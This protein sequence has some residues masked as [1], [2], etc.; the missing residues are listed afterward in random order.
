MGIVEVLGLA[1][2][3]TAGI[4]SGLG[5]SLPTG[6]G[7]VVDEVIQTDAALNPGNSGGPLLD[8]DGRVVGMVT[9]IATETG[10]NEGIGFAVPSA[11]VERTAERII[12][13][14]RADL[15]Y[16]G[17]VGGDERD[18]ADTDEQ[19]A[20][21]RRVLGQADRRVG[22]GR[23]DVEV[24]RRLLAV[25]RADVDEVARGELV[26]LLA[27][28]LDP[29]DELVAERRRVRR[30]GRVGCDERAQA[31]VEDPVVERRG[32]PVQA[33]LG[34]VADAAEQRL[35]PDPAWRKRLRRYVRQ[36]Q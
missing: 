33:E 24:E 31:A 3:V 28:C 8:M 5:R 30:R 13:T 10:R 23:G 34:A 27:R 26:D 25:R 11:V 20:L 22:R 21:Q 29:P 12:A 17:I 35:H 4:V 18:G 1:G 19:P 6:A 14:G 15:P 36:P 9:Q 32:P 2:S 7:R 16:L